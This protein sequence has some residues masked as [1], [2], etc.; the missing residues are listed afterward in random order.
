MIPCL[1]CETSGNSCLSEPVNRCAVERAI[2]VAYEM[3]FRD[4]RGGEENFRSVEGDLIV[5]HDIG[6]IAGTWDAS[7][8]DVD[9]LREYGVP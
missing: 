3:G 6:R 4:G 9:G 7:P 5:W 2:L 8:P 1:T